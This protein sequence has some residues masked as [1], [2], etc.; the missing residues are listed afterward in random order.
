VRVAC[1]ELCFE[2]AGKNDRE[3]RGMNLGAMTDAYRRGGPS[4]SSMLKPPLSKTAVLNL[5]CEA[6]S[7]ND[8]F[9]DKTEKTGGKL[10]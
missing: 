7:V 5:T 9:P 8:V 4:G 3:D 1:A 6:D 2:D 10:P